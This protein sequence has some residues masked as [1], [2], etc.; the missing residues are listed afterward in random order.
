MQIRG[1]SNE[2]PTATLGER[3][4]VLLKE[5][6][7]GQLGL[8]VDEAALRAKG[9]DAGSRPMDN[10]QSGP[11]SP[12]RSRLAL[13][14]SFLQPFGLELLLTRPVPLLTTQRARGLMG[15]GESS[16]ATEEAILQAVRL[17]CDATGRYENAALWLA[18]PSCA[19]H[20]RPRRAS[21]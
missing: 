7:K 21:N 2:N 6:T 16:P 11:G 17:G 14:A 3:I 4:Q 13:A 12:P 1:L 15:P 18:D 5:L 8:V 20:L 9:L 19:V 10:K